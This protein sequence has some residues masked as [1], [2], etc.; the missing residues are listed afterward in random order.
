MMIPITIENIQQ[1]L[2]NHKGIAILYVFA[3]WCRPC[4]ALLPILQAFVN[5]NP[6]ATLY[7]LNTEEQQDIA[8]TLHILSV[9][10]TIFFYNGFAAR[11]VTGVITLK[12]VQDIVDNVL[13]GKTN[14]SED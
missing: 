1:T 4:K 5:D 8:E 11:K 12:Q 6:D 7:S 10:T 14:A 13:K 2:L 9:P 3:T